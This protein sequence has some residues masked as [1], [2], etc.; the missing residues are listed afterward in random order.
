[1]QEIQE[2]VPFLEMTVEQFDRM[3]T[4]NTRGP[5]L[6]TRAIVPDMVAEKYGKII[7]IAS[8]TAL[9]GRAPKRGRGHVTVLHA[10]KV[11]FLP[12]VEAGAL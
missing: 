7:N 6:M 11:I 12:L 2:R 4:V 3:M 5:F 9:L 10:T 1:M 8:Q